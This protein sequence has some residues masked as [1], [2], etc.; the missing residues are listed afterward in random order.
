MARGILAALSGAFLFSSVAFVPHASNTPADSSVDGEV[1]WDGG[2]CDYYII[3]TSR[4]YVLAERYS[5][6]LEEG[7]KVSGDL[8]SYSFHELRNKSRDSEV[9]VY[10]ENYWSSKDTCFEWLSDH[11]KCD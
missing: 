6:R 10:V 3:E 1:I 7:D 8:H 4:Y 11:D 9:R 5:G 2:G